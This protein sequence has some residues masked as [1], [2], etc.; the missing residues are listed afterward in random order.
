MGNVQRSLEEV[1]QHI[2]S[3]DRQI[4]ALIAQHHRSRDG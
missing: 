4:V 1:R 2:D 3:L